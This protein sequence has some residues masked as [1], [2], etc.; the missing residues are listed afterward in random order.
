MKRLVIQAGFPKCGSTSIAAALKL[1]AGQLRTHKILVL[2]NQ[3][4]RGRASSIPAMTPNARA[5]AM[6]APESAKA[7]RENLEK[8]IQDAPKHG[9]LVVCTEI[10]AD[11]YYATFFAGLEQHCDLE[12]VFYFR[13]Q[14]Q[15][16]ASAWKQWELKSGTSLQKM[17]NLA[18]AELRPDYL[19]TARGWQS[20]IP[21]L[22]VTPRPFLNEM[23]FKGHPS[24]DFLNHLGFE[25]ETDPALEK[26]SNASM[27]FSLLHLFQRNS[28]RIF[29]NRHDNAPYRRLLENLPKAYR[30]V[31]IPMLS[32]R[33]SDKIADRFHADTVELAH[34]FMGMDLDDA[35]QLVRQQFHET[36]TGRAFSDYSEAEILERA[37]GILQELTGKTGDPNALLLEYLQQEGP[38]PADLPAP[39]A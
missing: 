33:Q 3:F 24:Y 23:M 22:K 13:P 4:T 11:P 36:V 5:A 38:A 18:V 27:D 35:E 15:W 26:R 12:L 30:S 7:L 21:R 19:G 6:H 25:A 20:E 39:K 16:I 37:G 29:K 34:R 8:S 32:Q 28:A 1:R 14:T 9:T 31:N 17:V 10:F 2:N